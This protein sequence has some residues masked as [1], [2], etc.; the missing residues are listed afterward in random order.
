M[1]S[2]FDLN[3]RPNLVD[4]IAVYDD[5]TKVQLSQKVL[6]N[7]GPSQCLFFDPIPLGDRELRLRLDFNDLDQN[8]DPMLD[9][10]LFRED[11][12]APSDQRKLHHTRKCCEN[13]EW[14]YSWQHEGYDLRFIVQTRNEV[15]QS[16]KGLIAPSGSV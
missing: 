15:T 14:C 2:R 13:G 7:G 6:G 16:G 1:S 10:S 5:G 11:E 4:A 3:K 12:K 8:G 9:A